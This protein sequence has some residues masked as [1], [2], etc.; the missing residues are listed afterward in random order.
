MR[1]GESS[2]GQALLQVCDLTITYAP[3]RGLPVHALQTLNFEVNAGEVLAILGES[4]SGKSTLALALLRL[5]PSFASRTG[6]IGFKGRDLHA[7]SD[8]ELQNIRAAEIALIPQDPA[9]VLNPVMKVGAQI[10]E[11]LRAHNEMSRAERRSRVEDL[12]RE[13]GF[14]NPKSIASAYPDQLS[15]GQRQ[16]I[17]IAQAI[18]CRPSLLIADEP[19]TKLDARLQEETLALLARIREQ[20]KTA[21]IFITH[22]PTLIAAFADRV[23]VMYGARIVEKGSLSD[24]FSHPLHPYTQALIAL[25]KTCVPAPQ[26]NSKSPFAIIRG[27]APDLTTASCGCR[28]E[29]RC[30]ERMEKCTN[31]IPPELI[32]QP[33]HS[34]SCFKYGC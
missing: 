29:P 30:Q 31:S 2:A 1:R 14:D 19:T 25:A 11:V 28:F 7:L 20:H 8:S 27:E 23:L 17:V 32:P 3:P 24:L 16:R 22:D 33:S 9:L 26:A 10:S 5:L 6:S 34:V 15:G 4:G 18:A 13:V 12:L 21:L